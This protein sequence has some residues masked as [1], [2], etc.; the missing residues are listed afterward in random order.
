MGAQDQFRKLSGGIGSSWIHEA[1]D[2]DPLSAKDGMVQLVYQYRYVSMLAQTGHWFVTGRTSAQDHELFKSI[3]T[4]LSDM[5]DDVAERAVG[6]F[7]LSPSDFTLTQQSEAVADMSSDYDHNAA[8]D[9]TKFASIL[10]EE[11]EALNELINEIV[12]SDDITDGT[13][14]LLEGQAD[15]ID[16]FLYLLGRRTRRGRLASM[17]AQQR[18]LMDVIG[19]EGAATSWLNESL[20]EGTIRVRD[21]K[22]NEYDVM[23]SALNN[24]LVDAG[25]PF[26]QRRQYKKMAKADVPRPLPSNVLAKIKKDRG[27]RKIEKPYTAADAA[28]AAKRMDREFATDAAKQRKAKD[29]LI[30]KIEKWADVAGED[31]E[32]DDHEAQ[33]VASD[34]A[35]SII[36]EPEI[37]KLIQAAGMKRD[38]VREIAADYFYDAAMKYMKKRPADEGIGGVPAGTHAIGSLAAFSKSEIAPWRPPFVLDQGDQEDRE[39]DAA[40]AN[41]IA[42][43]MRDK[44]LL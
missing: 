9:G 42:K 3:Y 21:E 34:M 10:V 44:G 20:D 43:K 38:A 41:K 36:D 14:N 8:H 37:K 6:T 7:E 39:K 15:E 23:D 11:L 28:K 12:E 5:L 17:D 26:D 32:G 40:R 1:E 25:I 13:R 35:L 30:D 19:R 22:G 18:K 4:K 2:D 27:T 31:F 33:Q 24:A 29:K 16:K